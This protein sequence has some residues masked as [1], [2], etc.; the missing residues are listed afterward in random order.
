M[1]AI[2][3]ITDDA[4]PVTEVRRQVERWFER[5]GVPHFSV[6][7]PRRELRPLV[8]SI[9]VIV[10]AFEVTVLAWLELTV[11]VAAASL[12]YV[13]AMVLILLPFLRTAAEPWEVT[14]WPRVFG[15]LVLRVVAF[16]ALGTLLWV[17]AMP[18]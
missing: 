2:P 12:A 17:T 5:Q 15:D 3:D 4:E 14:N 1:A 11:A 13:A 10:L 18:A 16:A 8:L 6:L 7:Y 9:L